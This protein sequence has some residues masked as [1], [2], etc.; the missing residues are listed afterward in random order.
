MLAAFPIVPVLT[1]I[2]AW[3]YKIANNTF[4]AIQQACFWLWILVLTI[5]K[6]L[7]DSLAPTWFPYEELSGVWSICQP[8]IYYVN[9]WFPLVEG[10]T[11]VAAYMAFYV[12]FIPVKITLRHLPFLGG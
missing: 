3:L 12:A 5:V 4:L 11:M 9:L 2:A 1:L 7:I 6:Y 10:T 8:Y